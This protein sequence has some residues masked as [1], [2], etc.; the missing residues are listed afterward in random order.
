MFVDRE[1]RGELNVSDSQVSSKSI[2]SLKRVK[3]LLSL[4]LNFKN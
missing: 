1:R 3:L 2:V 4:S